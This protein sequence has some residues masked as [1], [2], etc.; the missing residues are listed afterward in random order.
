[1]FGVTQE[2]VRAWS[3]EFE[4]F[5]SPTANPGANRTR[6]FTDEDMRVLALVADLRKSN[7]SFEDIRASL[8]NGE[9][10]EA[11]PFT[12]DQLQ[13]LVV[14]HDE[15]RLSLEV[16]ALSARLEQTQS[17]LETAL[18]AIEDYKRREAEAI[19]HQMRAEIYQEQLQAIQ[20]EKELLQQQLH[21]ALKELGRAEGRLE[22]RE[23]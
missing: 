1:M 16:E 23:K 14:R 19:K 11:P 5:L 18:Q 8:H 12:P 17:E 4:S 22:G 10:G 13:A 20:K 3:I 15:Q 2:T 9:R 21:E 7:A 6:L